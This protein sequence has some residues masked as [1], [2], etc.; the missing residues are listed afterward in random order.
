MVTTRATLAL[1]IATMLFATPG[2]AGPLTNRDKP[3]TYCPSQCTGDSSALVREL[4]LD[5]QRCEAGD[6]ESCFKA[7]TMR[8]GYPYCCTPSIEVDRVWALRSMKRACTLGHDDACWQLYVVFTPWMD[9]LAK[10][11]AQRGCEAGMGYA[12]HVLG[13][14]PF[15]ID[16]GEQELQRQ[17]CALGDPNGC[18]M[19]YVNVASGQQKLPGL[20]PEDGRQKLKYS[21]STY[22]SP[23][24][25][26]LRAKDMGAMVDEFGCVWLAEGLKMGWGGPT[27][28]NKARWLDHYLCRESGH[29]SPLFPVHTLGG[30]MM[31]AEAIVLGFGIFFWKWPRSRSRLE[32]MIVPTRRKLLGSLGKM[33]FTLLGLQ[34]IY[35]VW[36]IT[37]W[38]G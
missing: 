27:D 20:T 6:A 33:V 9:R 21:C 22:L 1:F 36:G 5:V 13:S 14:W 26:K 11:N 28:W 23:K 25:E 32:Q 2:R 16:G 29:C 15:T 17:A 34:L 18:A 3:T 4:D 7:S 30:L 37:G 24:W 38:I 10:D 31:G 19:A 12:C 35:T 8:M